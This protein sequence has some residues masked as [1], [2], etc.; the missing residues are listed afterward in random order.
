LDEDTHT[1]LSVKGN[2]MSVLNEFMVVLGKPMALVGIAGQ[3]LFSSRFIIQWIAS[4]RKRDSVMPIA[5]WY[6]SLVGGALT[7][8]YA[9]WRR[10][11][12]FLVAQ[13]S[14]LMVYT[15]N[16]ILIRNRKREL[17]IETTRDA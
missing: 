10:D 6:L 3:L 7:A 1:P 11:P 2:I 14:G 4:E 15:R 5:F 17:T 13:L 16:L 12:I 8:V 9:A